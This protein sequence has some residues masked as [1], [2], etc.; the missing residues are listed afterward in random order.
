M[1]IITK[2]IILAGDA[3]DKLHPLTLGIPKQ[4]LPIY[5]KPMISYPIETLVGV[6]ITDILIITSPQ[7]IS[8][9]V[10]ALGDGAKYGAKFTYA[11]QTS[12]EGAAQ[13]L[14]IGAHF[15]GNAPVCMI[16]GDCILE[17]E[18]VADKLRKALRAAKNSGQ[19]TIFVS[20]DYDPNQYGVAILDKAGK[21]CSVEGKSPSANHYSITGLYVFPKGVADYAKVLEK[22]ERGRY[23]V[24]SLNQAYLTEN[25]LQVQKFG[26]DILWF[27]TNSFDSLLR[28]GNYMQ[29]KKKKRL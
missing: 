13:A 21:C 5:D 29:S 12:P 8:S 11:T 6:G 4:L 25:K 7:H 18:G 27:D 1:S 3:G 10:Q 26:E 2:G 28:V 23:E 19:A 9:F 20:H 14:T 15:M 22:S 16:T 17:G 24:T